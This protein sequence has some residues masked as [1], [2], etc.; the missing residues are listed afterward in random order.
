MYQDSQ[1][2]NNF[3]VYLNGKL[4]KNMLSVASQNTHG[5]CMMS[6]SFDCYMFAN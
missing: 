6:G 3:A 4:E 5:T 1:V 2:D